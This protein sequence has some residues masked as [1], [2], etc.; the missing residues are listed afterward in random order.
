MSPSCLYVHPTGRNRGPSVTVW[1][2][3][4]HESKSGELDGTMN[5]YRYIQ[6]PVERML[7][8]ASATFE[9][10]FERTLFTFMIMLMTG[11]RLTQV[12]FRTQAALNLKVNVY[13]YTPGLPSNTQGSAKSQD[14][15]RVLFIIVQGIVSKTEL[16]LKV[17]SDSLGCDKSSC[18]GTERLF[19][20]VFASA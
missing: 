10:T 14:G 15:F 8:L 12:T 13:A 16:I 7:R 9:A 5:K 3:I 4:H 17:L 19:A 20:P 1:G 6:I 2:A 18:N 11:V